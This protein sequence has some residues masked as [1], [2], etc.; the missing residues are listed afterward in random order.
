[1]PVPQCP[2]FVFFLE[3]AAIHMTSI[4]IPL[5]VFKVEYQIAQGR[6]YFALEKLIFK[7]IERKEVTRI[8]DLCTMFCLTGNNRRLVIESLITLAKAEMISANYDG[9]GFQVTTVGREI[10]N[11]EAQPVTLNLER[12]DSEIVLERTTGQLIRADHIGYASQETLSKL[13][14]WDS[15]A[16]LQKAEELGNGLPQSRLRDLLLWDKTKWIYSIKSDSPQKEAYLKVQ[17]IDQKIIGLP[18]SWHS[19]LEEKIIEKAQEVGLEP[20]IHYNH[21]SLP[22]SK[23]ESIEGPRTVFYDISVKDVGILHTNTQHIEHL[24]WALKIAKSKIAIVSAFLDGACLEKEI[25]PLIIEAV[26]RGVNV[27][28]LWGYRSEPEGKG[29]TP[30]LEWLKALQDLTDKSKGKLCFNSTKTDSHAKLL[31]YDVESAQATTY[32]ACVGSYEWLSKETFQT[33]DTLCSDTTV[34]INHPRIVADLCEFIADCWESQK[35]SSS[36]D[37]ERW[38]NVAIDLY[39]HSIGTVEGEDQDENPSGYCRI[40]LVQHDE[41]EGVLREYL[42]KAQVRC[43]ILSHQIGPDARIRLKALKKPISDSNLTLKVIYGMLTENMKNDDPGMAVVEDIISSA[44]GILRQEAD[45]HS[46]LLLVDNNV[47]IGSDNFLTYTRKGGGN[48]SRE[49][50]VHL[51]HEHIVNQVWGILDTITQ[52][53]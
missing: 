31:V 14:S 13:G 32:S 50:S 40:K 45:V 29:E 49:I 2:Q 33:S 26:N 34:S 46:K 10:F 25:K 41:H 15:K 21:N 28:L 11:R 42:R 20:Q 23:D 8:G 16:C 9:N 52:N 17:V 39:K 43:A 7:A 22:S 5:T 53:T 18:P 4:I 12:K 48:V 35:N 37:Q 44:N 1:M 36:Q 30:G 24:I 47:V 19:L 27:D 3:G 38:R 6:P 51:Q